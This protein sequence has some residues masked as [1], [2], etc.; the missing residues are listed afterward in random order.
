MALGR[1]ITTLQFLN[2]QHT[3]IS[4]MLK[5]VQGLGLKATYNPSPRDPKTRPSQ[6]LDH[7]DQVVAF[8]LHRMLLQIAL[9]SAMET[10]CFQVALPHLKPLL[11]IIN[12]FS[13]LTPNQEAS[14]T[15]VAS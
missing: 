13:Q 5:M 15:S 2:T 7:L 12:I 1:F 4:L 11:A 14:K 10:A 8:F 6:A 9:A 3:A